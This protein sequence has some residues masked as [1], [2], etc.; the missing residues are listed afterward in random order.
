MSG[1]LRAMRKAP[2]VV[3][4]YER[5]SQESFGGSVVGTS[6]DLD[7]ILALPR[8]TPPSEG[9][10]L[11]MAATVTALLRRENPSCRC[12]E[13]RPGEGCITELFPVQGWY[14]WE[15]MTT[16]GVVG[17]LS[18][19]A[20]KTCL[21]I[22]LPMLVNARPT[23]GHQREVTAVVL[24]RP[25]LREQFAHDFE[26]W[27]QHFETP[28]L[29]GGDVHRG[30]WRGKIRPTLHVMA[31]SELS[32]KKCKNW[33]ATYKPDIISADECQNLARSCA[34][35]TGRFID[36]FVEQ[37]DTFLAVHSGSLTTRDPTDCGHLFALSL[38]EG[39]PLP[40]DPDTLE[41]WAGAVGAR[42]YLGDGSLRRLCANDDE[43]TGL[44]YQRRLVET[45][46][47]I[48][49]EDARLDIPLHINERRLPQSP[50]LLQALKLAREG[51]R[52]DRLINPDLEKG[53]TLEEQVEIIACC[54]QIALGFF[55][56]WKFP[57]GE[58]AELIGEWFAKRK[59]WNA[60]V[61][62]MLSRRPRGM[63]S[64]GLLEDAAKRF[65]ANRAANL[66]GDAANVEQGDEWPSRTYLAWAEIEDQV[67]PEEDPCWLD[68]CVIQDA[69]DWGKQNPG[70]VIWYSHVPFGQRLACLSG[71]PI[72]EGGHAASAAIRQERGD[73]TIIASIKAHGTGKNLHAFNRALV[74]CWP[75]GGGLVEQLLARHHRYLQ[76]APRVTFDV[77]QTTR[78]NKAAF[79]SSVADA[80]Y[81]KEKT[82]KAERLLFASSLLT[83]P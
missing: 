10:Q 51:E 32:S 54:R 64:P 81:V 3:Q 47:Y 7:R 80:Q 34:T 57:R 4:R 73:R 62:S 76:R 72:F 26:V 22:L 45:R 31:Y 75:A 12:A 38:K 36:H 19:G 44:G 43:P 2:K 82:G 20:G 15:A 16:G 61:R 1:V 8:R 78:E 59:S 35:R 25:D 79:E 48:S 40:I 13:L 55:S 5:R 49:T 41:E 70:G 30:Q 77:Y 74:T 23:E 67:Q 28:N 53:E 69:N 71:F 11:A 33:L 29:A 42:P 27:S 14:L 39:S 46:G 18:A 56:R 83:N 6:P 65:Y 66:S 24:L 37:E 52:P 68:D 17:H 9:D 60:E 50:R 21:G 58:S 63:D